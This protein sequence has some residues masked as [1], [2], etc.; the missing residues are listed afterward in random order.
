MM[1]CNGIIKTAADDAIIVVPITPTNNKIAFLIL[2]TIGYFTERKDI[3]S[4]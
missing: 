3:E 1:E 2:S 4:N